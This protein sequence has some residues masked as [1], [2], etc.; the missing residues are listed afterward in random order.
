VALSQPLLVITQFMNIGYLA[1]SPLLQEDF[2]DNKLIDTLS[3][4]LLAG[5]SPPLRSWQVVLQTD[6]RPSPHFP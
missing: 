2:T 6:V 4:A 3:H 5:C 1:N